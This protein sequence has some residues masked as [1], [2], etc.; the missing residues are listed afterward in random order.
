MWLRRVDDGKKGETVNL[1]GEEDP[2]DC[3]NKDSQEEELKDS[4]ENEVGEKRHRRGA[5][6]REASELRVIQCGGREAEKEK[7]TGKKQDGR[8]R[9]RSVET[10]VREDE[11][12]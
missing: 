6:W 2:D 11:L 10:K 8:R 4:G 5:P 9:Q 1:R 12:G 3:P 7:M